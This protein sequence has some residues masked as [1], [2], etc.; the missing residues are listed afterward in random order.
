MVEV[1]IV[2]RIPRVQVVIE[3]FSTIMD[4]LRRQDRR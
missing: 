3:S 1:R 2:E 4:V